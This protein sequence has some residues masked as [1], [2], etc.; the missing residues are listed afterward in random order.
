MPRPGSFRFIVVNDLHHAAPEC[1]GFFERLVA[2][3]R[4]HAPLAFC[5]VLGDLADTGRRESLEAMRR[6]L[7]GLGAPVHCVP[8]NHDCDAGRNTA[9]YAQIFPGQVNHAFGHGGWQFVAFDSTDGGGW[10][11][12][13]VGEPALRWIDATLAG[14]ERGAPTVAFTHFPLGE[15]PRFR[16]VNAM[17]TLDRLA[18]A[19]LRA[20]FC[21]HLHGRFESRHGDTV[22]LT[23]AC[24]SRVQK[25]HDGTTRQG[26]LLCTAH[27]DGRLEREFVEFE[28]ASK[29]SHSI[30]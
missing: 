25:N 6:I 20:V 24:C 12:T 27:A 13:S 29:P 22:V 1:D 10:E 21:G 30:L 2:Q 11:K 16:P 18:R 8:G 17:E 15:V 23:N 7:G 28:P 19:N 5:A 14:L 26:Y 3:M 9:L 4:G